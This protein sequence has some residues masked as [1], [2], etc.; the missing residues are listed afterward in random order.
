MFPHGNCLWFTIQTLILL[1]QDGLILYV[2][3]S[4]ACG[5]FAS[6]KT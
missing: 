2:L 6:S 3:L 4:K 5:C 1:R